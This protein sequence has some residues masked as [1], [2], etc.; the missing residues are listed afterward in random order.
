M[1]KIKL[2]NV[3]NTA[4][5]EL[6]TASLEVT[7]LGN[8]ER[9]KPVRYSENILAIYYVSPSCGYKPV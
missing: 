9:I 5:A 4:T 8:T 2:L 6:E 3:S 1:L 7:V